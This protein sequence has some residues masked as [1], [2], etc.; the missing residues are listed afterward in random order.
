MQC[1][2]NSHL[3]AALPNIHVYDTRPIATN[4]VVTVSVKSPQTTAIKGLKR[5]KNFIT[6]PGGCDNIAL[7]QERE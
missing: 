2:Q 7:P 3:A 4:G 6:H 5:I 1:E